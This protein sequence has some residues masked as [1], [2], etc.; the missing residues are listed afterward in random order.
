[1]SLP[2]KWTES[3]FSTLKAGQRLN[4]QFQ[5]AFSKSSPC[6]PDEFTTRTGLS[7]HAPG[8]T[9]GTI[10]I[11]EGVRRLLRNLNPHKASGPDNI[12]PSILKELADELTPALTLLY[13]SSIISG[14]VP[15]DW[16]TAHVTPIFKKKG[17]RYRPENYRPISLTS[18]PGKI[19]EHII[20]HTLTQS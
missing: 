10:T 17:E 16:R 1:M 19:L 2:S 18:V 9:C 20:V 3:L 11:T 5:S 15:Q 12:S 8:S 7:L 13:Q 6:P 14:V 4:R